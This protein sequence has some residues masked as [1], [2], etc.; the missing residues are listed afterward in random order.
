M[1]FGTIEGVYDFLW[2]LGDGASG[3]GGIKVIKIDM[4]F[5][6]YTNENRNKIKGKEK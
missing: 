1:G 2:G 6:K 3:E 5:M 4:V